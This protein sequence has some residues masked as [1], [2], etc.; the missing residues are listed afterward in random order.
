MARLGRARQVGQG[1]AWRGKGAVERLKDRKDGHMNLGD[2]IEFEALIDELT[3][4]F[5]VSAA[6]IDAAKAHYFKYLSDIT[7]VRMRKVARMAVQQ[8]DAFPTVHR[9]RELAGV[10]NTERCQACA[11]SDRISHVKALTIDFF[12]ECMQSIPHTLEAIYGHCRTSYEESPEIRLY[13]KQ[14]IAEHLG[15][16]ALPAR[17]QTP[18]QQAATIIAL[19]SLGGNHEGRN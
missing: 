16:S 2:R 15:L 3:D 6:R 1:P 18:E 13:A 5:P 14:A 8:L 11:G 12:S 9:L 4:I 17:F 19:S 10:T 7:L